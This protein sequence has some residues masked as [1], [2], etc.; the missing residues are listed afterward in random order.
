M[1]VGV[2]TRV[3]PRPTRTLRNLIEADQRIARALVLAEAMRRDLLVP[4]QSSSIAAGPA[5]EC[6]EQQLDWLERI[7][8]GE[9]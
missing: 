9:E 2:R 4:D 3:E 1:S 8:R 7:L 5:Y 6:A